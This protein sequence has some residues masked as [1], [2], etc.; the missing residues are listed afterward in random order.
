MLTLH[1]KAHKVIQQGCFFFHYSLANSM[2]SWAKMFT[3]LLFYACWD[4][5][6]AFKLGLLIMRGKIKRILTHLI[7]I[8]QTIVKQKVTIC[9]ISHPMEKSHHFWKQTSLLNS[10]DQY[11]VKTI[12][13]EMMHVCMQAFSWLLCEA[14]RF[15][16]LA[17]TFYWF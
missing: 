5:S 8:K 13:I 1:L 9:E 15:Y 2:T 12:L 10:Y 17:D 6:H 11:D 14:S 3:E 16:L 4:M 7:E